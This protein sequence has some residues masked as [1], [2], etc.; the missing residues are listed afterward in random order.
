MG[1]HVA[2]LEQ[3]LGVTLFA[4]HPRGLRLT[5][6]GVSLFEIAGEIRQRVD[7]LQRRAAGLEPD[8]GGTIR[9]ST[10]EVVALYVLPE[11]LAQLCDDHPELE[12]EVVSETRTAS[13]LRR[14]ADIAVRMYRPTQPDLIAT[15]VAEVTRSLYAS[16]HYIARHGAPPLARRADLAPRARL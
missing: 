11:L 5:E 13:L 12:V 16:R 2:D 10:S 1:R 4:R 3:R 9:V 6:E 15:K 14:D 7:A 8:I